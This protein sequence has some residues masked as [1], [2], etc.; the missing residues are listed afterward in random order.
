MG[1]ADF[2]VIRILETAALLSRLL[3]DPTSGDQ[4]FLAFFADT[5]ANSQIEVI[6]D[7]DWT[8]EN[9]VTRVV[10]RQKV[11]TVWYR[12]DDVD[13]A[14]LGRDVQAIVGQQR[15]STHWPSEQTFSPSLFAI[16]CSPAVSNAI[17]S[18]SEDKIL[19]CQQGLLVALHAIFPQR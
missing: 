4:V 11:E 5:D 7:C 18:D 2:S 17:V 15:R 13:G 8:C 9:R 3:G 12:R 14:S 1:R 6:I 16:H 10:F 19:D